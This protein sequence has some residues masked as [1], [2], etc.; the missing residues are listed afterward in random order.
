MSAV[1]PSIWRVPDLSPWWPVFPAQ[2]AGV[3]EAGHSQP[4]GQHC[5]AP[6]GLVAFGCSAW[7]RWSDR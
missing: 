4:G 1:N 2:P 6:D 3:E 5:R 7:A